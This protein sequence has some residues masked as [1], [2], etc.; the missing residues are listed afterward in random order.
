MSRLQVH[1]LLVLGV[2]GLL[3]GRLFLEESMYWVRHFLNGG[4]GAQGLDEGEAREGGDEARARIAWMVGREFMCFIG[5][6][7]LGDGE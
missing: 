2:S 5:V 6:V 4:K 7:I 3:V 1:S